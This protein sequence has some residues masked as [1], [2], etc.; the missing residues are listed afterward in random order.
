[1]NVSAI[2]WRLVASTVGCCWLVFALMWLLL[3]GQLA[4]FLNP[5]PLFVKAV[6]GILIYGYVGGIGVGNIATI[7]VYWTLVGLGLSW[8]FH[9]L[10]D[11]STV[12]TIF[13]I[14]HVVL[15]A[16]TLIPMMLLNGP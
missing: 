13:A 5:L 10:D 11:K 4:V 7:L 1:M 12:I 15:S 3:G 9:K 16:L 14:V 2:N 8:L 6:C